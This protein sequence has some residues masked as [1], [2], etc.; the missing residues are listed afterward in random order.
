MIRVGELPASHPEHPWQDP[1]GQTLVQPFQ[2]VGQQRCTVVGVI[3]QVDAQLDPRGHSRVCQGHPLIAAAA[4]AAVAVIVAMSQ[5]RLSRSGAC[6]DQRG[7]GTGSVAPAA[8]DAAD[9]R[10]GAAQQ[11]YFSQLGRRG[12]WPDPISGNL[13]KLAAWMEPHSWLFDDGEV[14][15]LIIPHKDATDMLVDP[16][17]S[18]GPETVG[19]PNPAPLT[20]LTTSLRPA[21]TRRPIGRS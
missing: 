7:R 10:S 20:A 5:L 15:R 6:Q 8:T 14:G 2:G 11:D 16:C 12:L 18:R 17:I 4:R 21:R 19:L 13:H 1:A 9:R 3:V